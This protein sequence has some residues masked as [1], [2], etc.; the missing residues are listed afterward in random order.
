MPGGGPPQP[1]TV[2]WLFYLIII[3]IIL[4]IK[5]LIVVTFSQLD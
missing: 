5:A 4:I 1:V 2:N 3:T